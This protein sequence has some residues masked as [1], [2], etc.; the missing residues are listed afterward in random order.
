[1]DKVQ[2]FEYTMQIEQYLEDNQVYELFENF[3][4]GLLVN[5]PIDPID[6]LI[7]YLQTD[8]VRRVFLMGPPGSFR[9]ENAMY[10]AEHFSWKCIS[11]GD[12]LRR[13][14]T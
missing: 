13:E 12:I 14:I 3:L 2:K 11:I 5:K 8:T 6:Y 4:K 1:M 9:H 7:D 10:L